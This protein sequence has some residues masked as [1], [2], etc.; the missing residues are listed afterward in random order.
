[1]KIIIVGNIGS[2]KSRVCSLVCQRHP[3]IKWVAID[4]FRRK[5]G[6]GSMAAES[7]A[8]GEFLKAAE[9]NVPMVI[10]CMG[11]GDL[12]AELSKKLGKS[13]VLVIILQVDLDTC[14]YRLGQ[15]VWDVPYPGTINGAFEL[16]KTAHA[17][18]ADDTVNRIFQA[19][20]DCLIESFYHHNPIHT[21]T[22]LDYINNWVVSNATSENY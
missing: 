12:A 11:R 1:M 22:I 20:S 10:E 13:P 14:I 9:S 17:D 2:G 21:S 4:E 3:N 16:C 19:N 5:F 18:Y 15:R 8:R 6:D 7:I